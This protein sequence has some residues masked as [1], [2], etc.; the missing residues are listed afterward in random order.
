MDIREERSALREKGAQLWKSISR[1][2]LHFVIGVGIL[3]QTGIIIQHQV[4]PWERRMRGVREMPA[5]ERGA[6]LS[7]GDEF[8]D[9][10]GFLRDNIP[11]ESK[12]IV[13]PLE[14]DPSLSNEGLMQYFLFPRTVINC[15]RIEDAEACLDLFSGER[16]YFLYVAG[17][18][19]Q[20][21]AKRTRDLWLFREYLGVFTPPRSQNARDRGL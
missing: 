12:V 16:T 6:R 14:V 7:F 21:K 5:W 11:E 10:I 15:P 4:L 19:P 20:D 8:A 3:I 13:P 1:W 9:Y 18:P 17:F 2:G